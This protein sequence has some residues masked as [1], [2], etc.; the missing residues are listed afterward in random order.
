MLPSTVC[1]SR[2]AVIF[3]A[4]AAAFGVLFTAASPTAHAQVVERTGGRVGVSLLGGFALGAVPAAA[5]T[6]PTGLAGL[7]L[8]F[9]GAVTDRFHLLGEFTL[10]AL[11]GGAISGR[12]ITA[13]HAGLN[14][15][16]QGYIGPRLFLR[17]GVGA[18]WAT[19]VASGSWFLPLP[20]P[21]VS[22]AVGYDL[23]R[24]GERAISIAIESSYTF[25]YNGENFI[26][27]L[28]TLGAGVGFDW[29]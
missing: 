7:S 12:D 15:A 19:A 23:W 24:S 13:F 6:A 9:G 4:A 26:D 22:G 3:T 14:L 21:R 17:G 10:L 1:S 20:G 18:G 5:T 28:F 25:L 2:R 29:Y 11:P 27:R 16:A 8:R